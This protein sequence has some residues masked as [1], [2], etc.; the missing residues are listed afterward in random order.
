VID[1]AINTA[2]LGVIAINI[3]AIVTILLVTLA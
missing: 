1:D 3:F 2:F